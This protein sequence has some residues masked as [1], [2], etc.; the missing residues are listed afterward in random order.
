MGSKAKSAEYYHELARSTHNDKYDYSLWVGYNPIHSKVPI[1]CSIHGIFHQTIANHLKGAGCPLCKAVLLKN[2]LNKKPVEFYTKKAAKIHNNF[3]DYGKWTTV[4]NTSIDMVTIICPSHG[5]FTQT[6]ASHI[7]KKAGCPKC[8]VDHR[9][10]TCIE[11]YGVSHPSQ[12]HLPDHTLDK[13][14][15]SDWLYNQ[16]TILR[17][18]LENIADE[19]GVQDTTVGKY[20]SAHGLS[21]QRFAVSTGERQVL[22]FISSIPGLIY[23]SNNRSVIAPKELDIWIPSHQLAIEYCGLYWH[24]DKHKVPEYHSIKYQHCNNTNIRLITLFDDEWKY[25]KEQV[26]LKIL[27][28]LGADPRDKIFARKCTIVKVDRA[29]K[30][31]FFNTNHIQGNGPGSI[32]IGLECDNKLVACMS[33]IQ[34]RDGAFTLNRYATSC[35]VVGGFSKL[36]THFKRNY[37]WSEI[38]SFADLRW[39]KGGVY[40]KNGFVL[41]KILPPDYSY[42]VN[43]KRVHKFNFR[44]KYLEKRLPD[45]DPEL[46]EIENCNRA[47]ILRIWDC[48]KLRYVMK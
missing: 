12:V 47:G 43:D 39:S 20:F 46:T 15:D 30:A 31:E 1:G 45:F 13:L 42:I 38:I 16:H 27:S 11:R 28:I 40:E 24:S 21:V 17:R 19:L 44:R 23:E 29:T 7:D 18:T 9:R 5:E 35:Q 6:P 10:T 36:L 33:F 32:N 2:G 25:N 8:A 4:Q 3:Y 41:D 34:Q 14:L 26:K 48:G 22:D 37:T